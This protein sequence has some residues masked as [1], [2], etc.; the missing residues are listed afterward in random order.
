MIFSK[1]YC[2]IEKVDDSFFDYVEKMEENIIC[3]YFKVK[4][5]LC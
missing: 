2:N 4:D 5:L 3:L 1:R